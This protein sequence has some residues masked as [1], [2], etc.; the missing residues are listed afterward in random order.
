MSLLFAALN[1]AAQEH[2]AAVASQQGTTY[3]PR[4]AVVPHQHNWLNLGLV[5][6]TGMVGGAALVAVLLLQQPS[7][8]QRE[9]AA[10]AR[11]S[12]APILPAPTLQPAVVPTPEVEETPVASPDTRFGI[13][14]GPVGDEATPAAN[15]AVPT[16]APAAMKAE[17]AV[18]AKQ[19]QENLPEPVVAA[20]ARQIAPY[21]QAKPAVVAAP[22]VKPAAPVAAAK[23]QAE[24]TVVQRA[25]AKEAK[26]DTRDAQAAMA[27]GDYNAALAAYQAVL[28]RAPRNKDALIGKAMALQQSGATAV[29][30][31]QWRVLAG[32]YP[33]DP[34]IVTSYASALTSIDGDA[35]RTLLH[36]VITQWPNFA[37]A[38]AAQAALDAKNGD[39]AAAQNAQEQAWALEK[40]N[41]AHRLN[42]AILADKRGDKTQALQLY[43]QAV[44]AY[45]NGGWKATLPMSWS[46]VQARIDYLTKLTQ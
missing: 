35:A 25:P 33:A 9:L 19:V 1:Q 28:D 46:A 38:L 15:P 23:P 37:P 11:L 4:V 34:A 22:V 27:R 12:M 41:P 36:G 14:L 5:L 2:R 31:A 26:L 10:S 32:Q 18:T 6:L 45:A 40:E 8:S 17:P 44:A 29:A 13:A 16:A 43:K 7:Y 3:A 20:I 30:L 24:I 42:L 39:M 21:V